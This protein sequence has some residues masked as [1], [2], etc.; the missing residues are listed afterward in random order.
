MPAVGC[1]MRLFAGSR[2]LDTR[3]RRGVYVVS[4]R[5]R[6]SPT[7]RLRPRQVSTSSRRSTDTVV[8]L[9][10]LWTPKRKAFSYNKRTMD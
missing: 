2:R 10:V 5:T 6:H 1:A 4:G 3:R 7:A 8:A 9:C